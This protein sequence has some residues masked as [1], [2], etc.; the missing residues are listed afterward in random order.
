MKK[1]I[2]F[3]LLMSLMNTYG[4]QLKPKGNVE[5]VAKGFPTFITIQGKGGELSGEMNL[6]GDKVEKATF[7]VPLGT[8]KT[9]M[10]LRDEHMHDKYL[11][12]KKYPKAILYLDSFDLKDEGEVSGK[13]KLHNN[14]KNVQVK[15]TRVSSNP[16]KIEA[17]FKIILGDYGI[18]I[19]SFQ[20]ITVAKEIQ[21][22]ANL[23]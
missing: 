4:A 7:V 9:G 2:I 15:Y 6:H 11:E 20:G 17:E 3:G 5:F 18:E 1:I 21:I 12:S 23:E 10:D 8:F 22:K 19:P 13:L 16:L 14:E